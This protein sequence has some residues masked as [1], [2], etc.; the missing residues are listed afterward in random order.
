VTRGRFY[1]KLPDGSIAPLLDVTVNVPRERI[2]SYVEGQDI[3]ELVR[4]LSYEAR[5]DLNNAP[6]HNRMRELIVRLLPEPPSAEVVDII[7]FAPGASELPSGSQRY[8]VSRDYT[9]GTRPDGVECVTGARMS[10]CSITDAEL[11]LLRQVVLH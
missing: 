5:N 8:V 9:L 1:L 2:V 10:A 4:H 7:R 11:L 6:L 3:N